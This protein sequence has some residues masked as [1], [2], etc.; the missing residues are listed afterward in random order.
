M[1]LVVAGFGCDTAKNPVAPEGTVLT[2]TASPSTVDTGETSTVT[3]A[4][5]RSD[6]NP[7]S[8]AVVQLTTS[9][10]ALS[11]MSLTL[12]AQGRGHVT[13][14]A[15]AQEGTA[16]VMASLEEG[17]A[18]VQIEVRG[19]QVAVAPDSLELD[20]GRA[21]SNCD[22]PINPKIAVSKNGSAA[23]DFRIIQD[24]PAWLRTNVSGGSVPRSFQ[25]LFTCAVGT[26]DLDLS[27]IL[28]VQGVD[29]ATQLDV[30]PEATVAVVVHVR[31]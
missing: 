21:T 25:A 24:L 2:M 15:P 5:F 27:H 11:A 28:R 14:T 7:A 8:G 6:G 9:I 12:D 20:H 30:G 26:G 10:G 23:L 19:P 3:V 18:S 22:D 1:Y 16:T 4:G 17:Q 13:F 31:D 29:P